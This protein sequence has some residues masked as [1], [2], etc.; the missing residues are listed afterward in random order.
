MTLDINS[1]FIISIY[2][3]ATTVS[4]IYDVE[5]QHEVEGS[6]DLLVLRAV[7]WVSVMGLSRFLGLH[8]GQ[9]LCR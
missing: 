5:W 7:H 6:F 4:L 2:Y 9:F 1:W 3:I 8:N